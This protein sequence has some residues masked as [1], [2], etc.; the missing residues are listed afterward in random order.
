MILLLLVTLA[1][2]LHIL[3]Y[4]LILGA[5]LD[6]FYCSQVLDASRSGASG[7]LAIGQGRFLIF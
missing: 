6:F 3:F 4:D 2:H 5:R 7:F 1:V